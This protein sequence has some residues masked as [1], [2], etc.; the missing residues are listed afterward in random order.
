MIEF[1]IVPTDTHNKIKQ[2][3]FS[4]ENGINW[5]QRYW[6]NSNVLIADIEVN[7]A[8]WEFPLLKQTVENLYYTFYS[9]PIKNFLWWVNKYPPHSFQEPHYHSQTVENISWNYFLHLP[10]N[11]GSFVAGST[12]LGDNMEG[13]IVFFPATLMHEVTP[14]NSNDIRYTI[15]GNIRV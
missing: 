7:V 10:P 12:A 2:H 15:S 4:I 5:H 6:P 9:S 11:S 1:D 8:D 13:Y 3:I 14:N